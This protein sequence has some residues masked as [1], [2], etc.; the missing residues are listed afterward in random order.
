MLGLFKKILSRSEAPQP[1]PSARPA[2]VAPRAPLPPPKLRVPSAAPVPVGVPVTPTNPVAAHSV[3]AASTESA[4]PASTNGTVRVALAAIAATLPQAISHK[5]PA[6]PDQFVTIPVDKILP[7]L[8]Y[9]QVIMTA[10]EL[11][12]CSP[13]YFAA[14]AGHDDLPISLP[15][16]DIIKQLTPDKFA[17]RQQRR[18]EVPREVGAIFAANGQGLSIAKPTPAAAAPAATTIPAYRAQP[19]ATSTSAQPAPTPVT[20]TASPTGAPTSAA[21]ISMSA[22]ALASLK[23]AAAAPATPATPTTLRPTI[24]PARAITPTPA[25]PAVVSPARKIFPLVA[26]PVGNLAVP[27]A[28]VCPEWPQEVRAQLSDVDAEQHQILVPLELLEPAMKSGRVLFLWEE[29]ASWL[30]PALVNPPTPKVGEMAVELSL[31]V[32]APL[33]MGLQRTG[34]Q[35]RVDV[36]ET[37]PDI[38]NGGNGNGQSASVP[39]VPASARVPM[40]LAAP[41][42]PIP[43]LV[44]PSRP[45]PAPTPVPLPA[46]ATAPAPIS[47]NTEETLE[48]I[49]G[50]DGSRL[51]AREIVINAGRL[52]GV[53]GALLALSDGLLVTSNTPPSIKAETIA[54]FLPQMFG[55]MNQYT[56]ELALGPLQQL[57]LG[58]EGAQ[59]H[60]VKCPN[61]YFAVLG[62]HGDS[63]P[64]NLLAQIAAE[65]S[66]QSK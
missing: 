28:S 8:Q 35:K 40:P 58:V 37:I 13:E 46:A 26:K 15:L 53:S 6:N 16:G 54:A 33:F 45:V 18:V 17:R 14:L 41:S 31:K 11:R 25:G 38:F 22:Q 29:V 4:E 59:W 2:P 60:V 64:L 55:R 48:Q 34:T 5:V 27:L 43:D 36:D 62:K 24:P 51:G 44:A 30:K 10:A 19:A 3:S 21:K 12:E 61:I 63:L 1:A 20:A 39:Q 52:P 42:A 50:S 9:G 65:L 56:K 32:I 49:I 23:A 66:S 47:A 57:T 7:Q